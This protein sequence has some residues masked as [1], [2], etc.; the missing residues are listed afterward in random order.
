MDVVFSGFWEDD[1]SSASI[2]NRTADNV[3]VVTR[4]DVP[5]RIVH[6]PGEQEADDTAVI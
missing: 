1:D 4:S 2:R 3:G 6:F 5:G